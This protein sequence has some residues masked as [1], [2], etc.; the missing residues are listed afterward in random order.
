MQVF[1]SHNSADKDIAEAIG[2][3]LTKR[4]ITVWIDSRRMTA[5][6]S[7]IEKIGEGIE[8]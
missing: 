5:G 8:G 7:L 2:G 1:L 3:F 6:D 4:G